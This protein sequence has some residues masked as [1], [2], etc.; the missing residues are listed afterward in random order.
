MTLQRKALADKIMILGVDGMDPSLTKKFLAEGIMP[1]VQKYIERGSTREDLIMQG[2][3]PTITPPMWTSMATGTCPG[4]HGIT[5]FWNQDHSSLDTMVY[6]LDSRKCKSE[7]L[8]NA[9]AEAGK[10]TAGY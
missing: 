7:P 4:T 2:A 8:W 5:C 6:A 9:F 10:K 1:N 3:H